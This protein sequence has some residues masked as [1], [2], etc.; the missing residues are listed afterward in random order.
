MVSESDYR[1]QLWPE[2][3]FD[4]PLGVE[5][6]EVADRAVRD[7]PHSVALW[8]RRGDLIQIV[9][10][11]EKFDDQW[12]LDEPLKCYL[13]AHGLAPLDP[14]TNESLGYWYDVCEDDFERAGA[15]FRVA[16]ENG[17]GPFSFVGLAR[18]EAQLGN[19]EEALDLLTPERCPHADAEPVREIVREIKEGSWTP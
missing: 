4:G 12:P 3:G 10:P 8:I 18:V 9:D 15:Y 2:G 19:L 7:H 5:V 16:I 11:D 17:G 1:L 14:K 13:S 6:L